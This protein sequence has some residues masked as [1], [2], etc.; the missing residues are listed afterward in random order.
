MTIEESRE[1][2]FVRHVIDVDEAD[3]VFV[4]FFTTLS[5]DIQLGMT[6]EVFRKKVGNED[7]ERQREVVDF[8]WGTYAWR[9][10]GGQD[11]VFVLTE[12]LWEL[13]V[14][15]P[16]VIMEEGFPNATGREQSIKGM[17]TDNIELPFEGMV[18][19]LDFSVFVAVSNALR[20]NWLLG[21]LRSFSKEQRD[22][23][24]RNMA[25]AQPIFEYDSGH[26]DG[27][28][29]IPPDGAVNHIWKKVHEK[30]PMIKEAIIPDKR[31]PPEVKIILHTGFTPLGMITY[32]M[33]SGGE[34]HEQQAA[35]NP[36]CNRV[37]CAGFG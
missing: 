10:Y 6:K 30:L 9:R 33:S 2:S 15:E 20:P 16:G 1:G 36:N 29:P 28:G 13:L 5:A 31:K 21:H 18:G 11:H 37:S 17:W 26:P 8:I 19:Y 32:T 27:I 7:Y 3:V 25:R 34:N 4:S 35:E 12:K 23:F 24:G 22:A 14:N